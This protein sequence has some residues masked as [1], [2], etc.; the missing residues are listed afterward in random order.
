MSK[1]RGGPGG[2]AA[3]GAGDGAAIPDPT[4]PDPVTG[5]P[6]TR[7]SATPDRSAPDAA[8][9]TPGPPRRRRRRVLLAVLA[10]VLVVVGGTALALGLLD[11]D[12]EPGA[13]APETVVLPSPTPTIAPV[14]RAPVSP[15]ADS[16]PSS[17]LGYALTSLVEEPAL[18][19]AGALEGYRLDYSDG[20]AGTVTV[21]AGQWESDA[22][23]A[24]ALAAATT[25]AGATAVPVTDGGP[26]SGEVQVGGAVVGGWTLTQAADGSGTVTWSN[27]TVV[28]QATGP[29]DV[30]RD[31]YAAYPY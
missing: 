17:V 28:L 18:L 9:A 26:T 25:A 12:R 30:V 23:A 11:G 13:V 24:T 21:T 4:T 15:F 31:V 20:A 8:A 3:A 27:G 16:L 7:G 29:A 2:S 14:E 5:D 10:G 1:A 19:A 6:T 22:D